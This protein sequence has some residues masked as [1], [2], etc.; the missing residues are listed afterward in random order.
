VLRVEHR[1]LPRAVQAVCDGS[2]ALAPDGTVQGQVTL[3]PSPHAPFDEF[4]L[5]SDPH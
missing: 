1:L 3:L 4:S 2:V 5:P